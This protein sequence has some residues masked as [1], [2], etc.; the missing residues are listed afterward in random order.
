MFVLC[1]LYSRT[2]GKDKE[3]VQMKYREP[4]KI[5]LG[6]WIFVF[7]LLLYRNK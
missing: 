7:F 5:L 4:K 3:I 6:V 2:K 1:V